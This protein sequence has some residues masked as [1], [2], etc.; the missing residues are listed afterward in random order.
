MEPL[1]VNRAKILVIDDD[2]DILESLQNS[3]ELPKVKLDIRT[4]PGGMLGLQEAKRFRPDVVILDLQM[5]GVNGFEVLDE[6]RSDSELSHTK[7]IML[8]AKDDSRNLWEGIDRRLDDFISKPFD[9]E[10][11]EARIYVQLLEAQK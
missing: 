11:L 7:V 9:L 5:P 8:T 3:L 4:A 2:R 1:R 6:I 10:E